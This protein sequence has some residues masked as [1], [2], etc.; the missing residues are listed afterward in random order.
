ME[1]YEMAG[2]TFILI[3][4]VVG[5]VVIVMRWFRHRERLAMIEVGNLADDLPRLAEADWVIEVVKEDMDIKKKVLSAVA[6]HI[7]PEAIFSS[8][9]SSSTN[10]SSPE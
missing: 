3:V 8:N 7:G 1:W 4:F 9:T 10:L 5:V 6:P 2:L